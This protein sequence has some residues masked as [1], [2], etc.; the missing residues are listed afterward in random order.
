[1]VRSNEIFFGKS[2]EQKINN[3]GKFLGIKFPKEENMKQYNINTCDYWEEK[4]QNQSNNGWIKNKIWYRLLSLFFPRYIITTKPK[5][6][7]YLG[8]AKLIEGKFCDLGC[9]IGVTG[10]LYSI[11]TGNNCF[12]MDYSLEGLKIAKKEAKRFGSHCDYF[13]GNIYHIGIKSNYFD[14]VYIGQVLEHLEDNNA[15]L[16]EAMRILR[17]GG[18]L[19]ISVPSE[20]APDNLE[21]INSYYPE[22]IKKMLLECGCINISF[23]DI[24]EKRY[25][26]SAMKNK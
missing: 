3:W 7:Y 23:H 21:H 10:G 26:V 16:S 4:W 11:L 20:H 12:G 8:V 9:G 22:K 15:A 5:R 6:K 24:D 18:K 25:V 13:V 19:I 1:M 17:Q 2:L 14:T